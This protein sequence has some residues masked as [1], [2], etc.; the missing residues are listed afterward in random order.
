M[1]TLLGR[2]R[3]LLGRLR[4]RVL[5]GGLR[6]LL[7]RLRLRPVFRRLRLPM[8][9]VGAEAR[10]LL[11]GRLRTTEEPARAG[12]AQEPATAAGVPAAAA[13]DGARRR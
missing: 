6:A 2:V 13:A 11:D 4:L 5:L 7:G 10:V 3:A 9:L 1:R 12:A 8:V